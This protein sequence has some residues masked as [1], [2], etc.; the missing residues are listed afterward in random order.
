MRGCLNLIKDVISYNERKKQYLDYIKEHKRNV[1][2]S[3]Y[4]LAPHLDVSEEIIDALEEQISL[5]D[6]SKYNKEEFIP[7]LDYFYPEDPDA[8]K[9]EDSF[10]VAFCKHIHANGHHWQH[11]I[12][13]QDDTGK[14][15]ALDM[16][17]NYVIEMLADWQSFSA[18]NPD[19]TAYNWYNGDH[20]KKMVLSDNT[21]SIVEKYIGF[22]KEPLK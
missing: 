9:D 11:W 8:P 5:H 3:F 17:F 4:V 21:R 10:K 6:Q 12:L 19:S 20:G 2:K 15:E 7:Y 13:I 18:K 1:L 14:P 22:L 16:P